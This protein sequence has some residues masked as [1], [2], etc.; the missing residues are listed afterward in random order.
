MKRASLWV[1]RIAAPAALL[2]PTVLALAVVGS[3]AVQA[4]CVEERLEPAP[5][6]GAGGAGGAGAGGGGGAPAMT[7]RTVELRNPYGN[8]ARHDNLLW[9]GDFEWLSAFSS[10]Y[11][12]LTGPSPQQLSYALPKVALGAACKS[13]IKCARVPPNGILVGVGVAKEGSALDVSFAVRVPSGTCLDVEAA[14]LSFE[15]QEA[16]APIGA[17]AEQPTDG[18]CHYAALVP[19]RQWAPW[20]YIHNASSGE[21]VVDDAVIAPAAGGMTQKSAALAP[22]FAIEPGLFAQVALHQRPRVEPPAPALTK[23]SEK[24]HRRAPWH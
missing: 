8:V 6:S 12:W 18:W 17:D 20:L 21:I 9:D 22:P 5:G 13:G 14:V 16:M 19:E 10:Q 4:S 1:N 2:V 11:G 15:D 23:F 3:V 24:R 7:K